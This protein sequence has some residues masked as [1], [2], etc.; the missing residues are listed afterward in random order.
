MASIGKGSLRRGGWA[1]A[2]GPCGWLTLAKW[3]VRSG[4]AARKIR[5]K[6]KR[7]RGGEEGGRGGAGGRG[8][9]EREK[10]KMRFCVPPLSPREIETLEG[11][12]GFEPTLRSK[13]LA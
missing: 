9:G 2:R 11:A 3:C 4:S 12:R 6:R 5:S 7:R 10:H 13:R 8:G 1:T